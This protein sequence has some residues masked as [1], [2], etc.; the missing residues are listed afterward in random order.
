MILSYQVYQEYFFLS[1]FNKTKTNRTCY[2]TT[3]KQFLK[4]NCVFLP[5]IHNIIITDY[6]PFDSPSFH[7][8]DSCN[9]GYDTTRYDVCCH[10]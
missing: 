7:K 4:S 8:T 3:Y 6:M 1:L 5:T 9:Q 2:Q 10:T